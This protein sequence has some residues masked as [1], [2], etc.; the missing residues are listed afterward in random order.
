MPL[1]LV[2]IA[3]ERQASSARVRASAVPTSGLRAPAR[4]ARPMPDRASAQGV[5]RED[6]ARFEQSVQ[7]GAQSDHHVHG[8]ARSMRAGIEVGVPATELP[9][10]IATFRPVA[11][12]RHQRQQ[13]GPKPAG[14]ERA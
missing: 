7:A 8:F 11:A 6:P 13:R 10:C 3:I 9:H 4:T 2:E 12:A 5:P 1:A 14:T